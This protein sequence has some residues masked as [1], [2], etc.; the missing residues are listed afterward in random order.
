MKAIF[1]TALLTI[2]FSVTASAK[3]TKVCFGSGDA[4]GARFVA[5]VSLHQLVISESSGDAVEGYD[6]RYKYSSDLNGRDGK[7]Y[8]SFATDKCDEG[9]TVILVDRELTASSSKGW[10]KLRWSGESF[11][12]TKL[13]CRDQE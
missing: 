6:G 9:C 4:K 13:F 1:L 12:E 11:A 2:G 7:T 10:I 3:A 5:E 8:L